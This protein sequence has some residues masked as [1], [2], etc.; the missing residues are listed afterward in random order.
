M[1]LETQQ[2][3]RLEPE[4]AELMDRVS[5]WWEDYQRILLIAVAVMVLVGGGGYLYLR[6]QRTQE[7]QAA[8]QLAEASVVFWQGDYNRSLQVAKQAYTQYPSTRSGIDAHRVAGDAAFWLG[9]FR[10]AVS[11]YRRY[12]DKVKSGELADAARR[13]LAYSLESNGQ[14]QDAAKE[15]DTLVDRFDRS[16]SAELLTG[17]ARCYRRLNQ[18]AEIKRLERV[19]HEFGDVLARV[20]LGEEGDGARAERRVAMDAA[21]IMSDVRV[22]LILLWHQHQPDYRDPHTGR[23]RLP[24]VRL[25]ATKDYVDMARRLE[26]FPGVKATFNFVPS[27]VDQIEDAARGGVDDLF[28][29]L[30]LEPRSLSPEQRRTLTSRCAQI[31]AHALARSPAL[32]ALSRVAE[33]G[34]ELDDERLLALEIG[35]LLGWLDPMFHT[36]KEAAGAIGSPPRAAARDALLALHA[37]STIPAHR[38]LRIVDRSSSPRRLSSIL[39]LLI[40]V[41]VAARAVPTCRSRACLS[42]RRRTPA[43]SSSAR[44]TPHRSVRRA[45]PRRSAVRNA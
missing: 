30:T 35:F 9:D 5:N 11:E 8:G 20:E 4:G 29:L 21:V 24:W 22:E 31:P 16:T 28:E 12:L 44:R 15:Y 1:A 25:H 10:N 26:P 3:R 34:S 13:S 40:D 37:G 14:T 2:A 7:D 23:S 43:V 33:G 32:A 19:V 6:S 45:A 42:S 41:A 36:A 39:P 17:A 27:L 38:G 18:P